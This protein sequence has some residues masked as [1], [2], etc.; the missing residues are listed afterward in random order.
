MP[1]PFIVCVRAKSGQAGILISVLQ[2]H[3]F[4]LDSLKF[5]SP[6]NAMGVF[7]LAKQNVPVCYLIGAIMR[8]SKIQTQRVQ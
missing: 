7:R 5:N 2:C 3:I 8:G 1:R 4:G 6:I